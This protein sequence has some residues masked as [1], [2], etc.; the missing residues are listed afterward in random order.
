[1]TA[2]TLERKNCLYYN[3]YKYAI[4]WCQPLAVCLKEKSPT[5]ALDRF[6]SI[7]R[8]R[9]QWHNRTTFQFNDECTVDVLNDILETI[10]L[11]SIVKSD[12]KLVVAGDQCWVYTNDIS[13]ISNLKLK[14]PGN[15]VGNI[16]EVNLIGDYDTLGLKN[17]KYPFRSYFREKKIDTEQKLKLLDWIKAQQGQVQASK[18]T[19]KWLAGN[20]YSIFS[21]RGHRSHTSMFVDH[22]SIQHALVLEML[23]PKLIKKTMSVISVP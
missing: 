11:L 2:V 23:C 13:D 4:K 14:L 18:A 7:K 19:S 6:N 5:G 16:K 1:M 15:N 21:Y 3:Q 8:W 22:S 20:H 10:E 9:S 12:F 17:A